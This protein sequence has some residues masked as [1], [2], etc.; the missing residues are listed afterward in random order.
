MIYPVV[1][2]YAK[3]EETDFHQ[4]INWEARIC[5]S[6]GAFISLPPS[7]PSDEQRLKKY[8]FPWLALPISF[9]KVLIMPLLPPYTDT[10]AS[11]MWCFLK[12]NELSQTLHASCHYFIVGFANLC[13]CLLLDKGG[14]WITPNMIR[15]TPIS[16]LIIGSYTLSNINSTLASLWLLDEDKQI[17]QYSRQLADSSHT[18]MCRYCLEQ[19]KFRAHEPL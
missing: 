6:G 9:Y 19:F 1:L 17:T 14:C 10:L 12:I 13:Q 8:P 7:P 2:V 5:L 16:L 11:Q 15:N 18:V 4:S 3:L